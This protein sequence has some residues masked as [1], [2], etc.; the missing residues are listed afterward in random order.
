MSAYESII[1]GVVSGLITGLIAFAVSTA[2]RRVVV[3]WYRQVTYN[4]VQISGTWQL[5]VS[6]PAHG[7]EVTLEISQRGDIVDGVSTHMLKEQFN[8]V[9]RVRTYKV[10]GTISDRF[11]V[12]NGRSTD[13]RRL[14]AMTVLLEIVGDGQA[15]EGFVCG[16]S[17]RKNTVVGVQ[18]RM[19]RVKD[20]DGTHLRS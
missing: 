18:A 12:L 20:S 17:S 6:E 15:M 13:A 16:Y 9:D 11:L 7:R 5:E 2:I 14:G 3:P 4:G 8:N 10:S 1:L 19:R